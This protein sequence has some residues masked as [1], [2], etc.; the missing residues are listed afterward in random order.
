MIIKRANYF[1]DS[2]RLKSTIGS[3]WQ[4]ISEVTNFDF[5]RNEFEMMP[6]QWI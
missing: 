1:F 2:C 4:N 3:K 6:E 5:R